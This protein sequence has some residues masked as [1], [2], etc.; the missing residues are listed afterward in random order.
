[1]EVGGWVGAAWRR[2][3]R[4]IVDAIGIGAGVYDRLREQGKAVEGFV[5]SQR[6][7][8]LDRSGEL[9]FANKRAAAWWSMREMLDPA[10]GE[11][12]ALPPDDDLTGELTAPHWRMLSGGKVVIEAK[13]EVK[14]RLGR[15]ADKADAVI[16][17]FWQE[18]A[19][20][21]GEVVEAQPYSISAGS[22]Y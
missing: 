13:E 21:Y 4:A 12:V 20:S 2:G 8:R 18:G 16:Q 9:A 7:D 11:H 19:D 3:G 22:P 5:A 14:A 1:M 10:Y 6:T 15:S 17:A